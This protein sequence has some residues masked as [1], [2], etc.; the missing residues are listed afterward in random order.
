MC[1]ENMEINQKKDFKFNKFIL[2]RRLKND[3]IIKKIE[4]ILQ[5]FEKK[6]K[7]KIDLEK[8]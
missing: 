4:K 3:K 5:N 7:N 1:S 2:F 6:T 8:N